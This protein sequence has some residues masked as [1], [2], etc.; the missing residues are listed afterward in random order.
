[1][2]VDIKGFE[3]LYAISPSG[4]IQSVYRKTLLKGWTESIGYRAVSLWKDGQQKRRT[5]HSLLAEAFLPNS[6]NLPEVNHKDGVK[7][8]NSLD[9]LEWVSGSENIRHAFST[10]LT[11]FKP[12]IDY[13]KVPSILQEV[14]AGTPLLDIAERENLLETST[15][16]KLLKREAIRTGQLDAFQKG[17]KTAKQALVQKRSHTILQKTLTGISVHQHKSI[18]EAARSI[19]C[20]PSAIFK[21]LKH[22]RPFRGYIW[23][24]EHA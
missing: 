1:M 11:K 15:L 2:F 17:T 4:E 20:N 22:V 9:N 16:R 10:G 8:N 14:L 24:R 13:Q 6:L 18:N 7:L 3:G 12:I 23:E 21:A 5:V 19:E